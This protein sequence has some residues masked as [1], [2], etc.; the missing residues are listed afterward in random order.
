VGGPIYIPKFSRVYNGR[1]KTFFFF[2]FE[3]YLNWIGR[4]RT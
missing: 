1:N 2:N 3:D 4:S